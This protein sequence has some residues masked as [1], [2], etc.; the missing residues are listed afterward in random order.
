MHGLEVE[1][2]GDAD[3][4]VD[5]HVLCHG[6]PVGKSSGVE[7]GEGDDRQLDGLLPYRLFQLR[8]LEQGRQRFSSEA[9]QDE[10]TVGVDTNRS[11]VE[12]LV[13]LALPL[14]PLP[15]GQDPHARIQ[16][17]NEWTT[18]PDQERCV[19]R[20]ML[21]HLKLAVRVDDPNLRVPSGAEQTP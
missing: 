20:A 17:P 8:I 16:D 2:L 13:D 9:G 7:V 3:L 10:R 12:A 19:E 4:E 11:T 15:L 18:H 14:L 6:V 21:S 5:H 1:P